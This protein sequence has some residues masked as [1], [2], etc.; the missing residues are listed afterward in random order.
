MIHSYSGFGRHQQAARPIIPRPPQI[1]F[2]TILVGPAPVSFY[3]PQ[4]Q[5]AIHCPFLYANYANGNPSEPII[6]PTADAVTF[7]KVVTWIRQQ[8]ILN[9][10]RYAWSGDPYG[11]LINLYGMAHDYDMVVLKSEC[12]WA[13]D[14]MRM[15][16]GRVP[17]VGNI[18]R[19]GR[20]IRRD[21]DM[22]PHEAI[23]RKI[24]NWHATYYPFGVP[25]VENAIKELM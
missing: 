17:N 11:M 4:Q 20:V 9:L 8:R 5:L 19:I 3:V 1:Q 21:A 18:Q 22:R 23:R 2:I 25:G 14:W 13:M 6:L 15:E 24:L 10:P 16:S 7:Q 12:L